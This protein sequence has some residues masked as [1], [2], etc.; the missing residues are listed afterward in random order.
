MAAN[1]ETGVLQPWREVLSLRRQHQVR[2]LVTL[3]SGSEKNSLKIRRMRVCERVRAQ[4][5]RAHRRRISQASRR[6]RFYPL[7]RGGRGIRTVCRYGIRRWR[8]FD[9]PALEYRERALASP[10]VSEKSGCESIR[11]KLDETVPG[12][13]IVGRHADRLWNTVSVLMPPAE[14]RQRWAV[15]LESWLCRLHGLSVR[16]VAPKTFRM[17]WRQWGMRRGGGPRVA[18]QQQLGDHRI[19]GLH[20]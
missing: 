5:R 20:H 2:R 18:V 4:I 17:F 15:K 19:R 1:N 7:L 16:R 13:E 6:G 8:P 10:S 9:D 11:I 3:H 12:T 14:C